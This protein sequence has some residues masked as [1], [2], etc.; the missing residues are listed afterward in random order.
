MTAAFFL[1]MLPGLLAGSFAGM[2]IHRLPRKEPTGG[3]SR[4]PLCRKTLAWRDLM[5][6]L[7]YLLL[8]GKCRACGAKI[9]PRYPLV[10]LGIGLFSGWLFLCC[11]PSPAYLKGLAALTCATVAAL[12]D[13]EHG[14]IPDRLPAAAAVCGGL[15]WLA[16]GDWLAP[17]AGALTAGLLF[18]AVLLFRGFIDGGDVK[19]T[20]ALGTLLGPADARAVLAAAGF[21]LLVFAALRRKRSEEDIPFGPF[22][23]MGVLVV[24]LFRTA[25]RGRLFA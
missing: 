9:S 23:A 20:A 19:F 16:E 25:A 6:V 17:A 13:L 8:R 22:L 18:P 3:R 10:E 4:C 24:L 21:V 7:G 5:P 14:V 12:T 11:G 15:L 1:G 2:L